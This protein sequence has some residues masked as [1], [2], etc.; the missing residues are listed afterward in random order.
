MGKG[1]EDEDDDDEDIEYEEERLN[2]MMR[3]RFNRHVKD[4]RH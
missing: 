4:N 1:F 3:A 2:E